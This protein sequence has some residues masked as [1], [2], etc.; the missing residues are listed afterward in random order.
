MKYF[1][2]KGWWFDV[3]QTAVVVVVAGANGWMG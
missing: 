3:S 2:E 1:V